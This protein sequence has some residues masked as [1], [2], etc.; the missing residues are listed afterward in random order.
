MP[1]VANNKTQGALA[2]ADDRDMYFDNLIEDWL[3]G[4]RGEMTNSTLWRNEPE[5]SFLILRSNANVRQLV[6]TI[7]EVHESHEES[8]VFLSVIWWIALLILKIWPLPSSD[9]SR[10][11]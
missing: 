6:R 9:G 3:T 1:R 7:H 5:D 2:G 10:L 4:K 8:L 11:R